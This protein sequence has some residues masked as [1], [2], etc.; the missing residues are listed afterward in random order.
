MNGNDRS[1]SLFILEDRTSLCL[2][3]INFPVKYPGAVKQYKKMSLWIVFCLAPGRSESYGQIIIIEE[4]PL[5][6]LFLLAPHLFCTDC[7]FE[8]SSARTRGLMVSRV[9]EAILMITVCYTHRLGQQICNRQNWP[10][11]NSFGWYFCRIF[12]RSIFWGLHKVIPIRSC[13]D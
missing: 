10:Y 9:W 12:T 7:H 2:N 3:L 5:S 8:Q 1:P 6:E 11:K 4:D 13:W